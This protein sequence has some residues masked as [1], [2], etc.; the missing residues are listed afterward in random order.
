MSTADIVRNPVK[1]RKKIILL[2]V[3]FLFLAAIATITI[4]YFSIANK[5]NEILPGNP[6]YAITKDEPLKTANGR[7]NFLIFGTSY[8]DPNPNHTGGYLTD[9]LIILSVNQTEKTAYTISIPRD[10]WVN[11]PTNCNL[12]NDGKINAVY[13]CASES[14][15][16]S[17][18]SR[19]IL[20]NKI[21]EILNLE[22]QYYLEVNYTFI[23]SL[24]DAVGGID[25]EIYSS[26]SR[27]IYDVATGLK[28]AAGMNHLDGK[29]AL[30]LARARNSKGGYGLPRSNFDREINQQRILAAIFAKLKNDGT[31]NNFDG[32]MKLLD[33]TRGNLRTNIATKNLKNALE[34]AKKID[35]K[36]VVSIPITDFM[37]T[38]NLNNQSIVLPKSGLNNYA[39][40]QNF[41]AQKLGIS[42]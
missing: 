37:T 2:V 26:D 40:L 10:L 15:G 17:D 23:E 18:K 24:T 7:T 13:L 31:L 27:G 36:K 38:G 12:G 4:E 21:G 20:A 30:K 29:T 5:I 6:L 25:V 8:D 3:V 35:P 14:F 22:I 39:D 34:I 42:K 41:V 33:A 11:F 28:L 1:K 16:K 9:S 19:E 32:A